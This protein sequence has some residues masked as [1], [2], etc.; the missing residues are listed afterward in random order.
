MS[1]TEILGALILLASLATSLY[2]IWRSR[3]M[4]PVEK[5]STDA[6]ASKDYAEAAGMAADQVTQALTRIDQLE[7]RSLDMISELA[8]LKITLTQRDQYI[9]TLN[10]EIQQRDVLIA[11]WARGIKILSMQLVEA[12]IIPAWIPKELEA[13]PA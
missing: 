1:V 12:R 2:A 6:G 7:K 10:K 5:A 8:G 4:Y 9:E 11:E 3:K 13:Q